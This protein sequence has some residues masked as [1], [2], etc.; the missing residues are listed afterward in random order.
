MLKFLEIR[1][2]AALQKRTRHLVQD[3]RSDRVPD[4]AGR[5]V[6]FLR[7]LEAV[8]MRLLLRLLSPP[9]QLPRANLDSRDLDTKSASSRKAP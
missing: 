7:H 4:S 5:R 6:Q 8:L 2:I 3:V 9:L 1:G